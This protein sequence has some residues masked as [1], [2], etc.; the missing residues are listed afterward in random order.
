MCF[1]FLYTY[2]SS[3]SFCHYNNS[4]RN[5]HTL[6]T[7][8]STQNNDVIETT[9]K[10]FSYVKLNFKFVFEFILQI[11]NYLYKTFKYIKQNL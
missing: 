10:L 6:T 3:S 7:R 5:V 9:V 1:D 11:M 2:T 4:F 8:G